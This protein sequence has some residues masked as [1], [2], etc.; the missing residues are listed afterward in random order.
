V[1]V[2]VDPKYYTMDPAGLERAITSRTKAIIPV[3]LYGQAAAMDDIMGIAQRHG[4]MVLED[5]CQ[6]HL[7]TLND[8]HVGHYGVAAAFSFYPGKNLG[9]YGEAGAVTTNDAAL[10]DQLRILRDHGQVR[11]YQHKTWGLNYRLDAIQAMVLNVKMPH[12]NSWTESRRDHA[13]TYSRLLAGV[14]DVVCPA[15]RINGRHVYHLYVIQTAQRD[16]LQSHLLENDIHTGLHYPLPL[17][18]QE[19]YRHLGGKKGDFPVTEQL[20]GRG[21]SLPMFA[22]LTTDQLQYVCRTI[23]TFFD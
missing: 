23:K 5:A 9:A 15:E 2:D 11:K 16:R 18:M 12:L 13:R 14:G 17:H 20:A 3:H 21:L 4:V 8:K 6:A 22:E 7:A 10:A 19:A 1:F